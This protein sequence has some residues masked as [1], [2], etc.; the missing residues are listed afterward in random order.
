MVTKQHLQ[1]QAAKLEKQIKSGKLKPAA[2][3]K[4]RT[5]F[6]NYT[7]RAKGKSQAAPAVKAQKKSEKV[8]ANPKQGILPGFLG[9]LNPVRIEEMIADRAFKKIDQAIDAA[10]E[11]ILGTKAS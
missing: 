11:K 8:L 6:Y 7:R 2:L 1:E 4:A 5:A 9:Q 10:V 3:K